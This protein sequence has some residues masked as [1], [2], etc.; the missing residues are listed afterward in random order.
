[1]DDII[2]STSLEQPPRLREYHSHLLTKD[3]NSDQDPPLQLEEFVGCQNWA[4]LIVGE[5]AAL[6]AWKKD[7][8][9]GG[10]LSTAQLVQRVNVIH[11]GSDSSIASLDVLRSG[12]ERGPKPGPADF[13]LYSHKPYSRDFN[14]S[15]TRI[16]AYAARLYFLVVVSGWKLTILDIRNNVTQMIKLFAELA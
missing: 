9:K 10:K 16:W 12:Q 11:Q 3:I 2:S 13:E 8:K 6:D 7:M 5:I 15:I 1:M 4:L 14:G